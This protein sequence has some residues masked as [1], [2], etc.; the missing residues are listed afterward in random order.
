[1]AVGWQQPGSTEITVMSGDYFTGVGEPANYAPVVDTPIVDQTIEEDVPFSLVLPETVFT[2]SDGDALTL[3]ATLSNGDPLPTWLGFDPDLRTLSGTPLNAHV[4]TLDIAIHADDGNGGVVSD[5]FALAVNNRNDAP[6]VN[7]LLGAQTATE[8]ELLDIQLPTDAFVDVDV[9]DTLDYAVALADGSALPEW[10]VFDRDTLRLHGTPPEGAAGRVDVQVSA[11][12]V[13]GASASQSFDITVE[14]G[15][16]VPTGLLRE[17]WSGVSGN[18]VS[19]LTEHA[20]FIAGTPTGS[21]LVSEFAGPTHWGDNYGTRI[22]GVFTAAVSGDYTFWVS[23]D[24]SAELWLSSDHTEDNK[25]R[26]VQLNGYTC[27][28]YTSPSPRDRG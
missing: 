18:L 20:D 19:S 5:T 2:D 13:A 22:S 17:W 7:T 28:L 4:G 27:L 16:P 14:S 10:L 26:I 1:M 25:T 24:N 23:G 15:A 9:D 12:D 6:T 3:T 11:T 21:E 8:G